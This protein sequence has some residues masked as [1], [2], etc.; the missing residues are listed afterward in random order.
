M[1]NR[2]HGLHLGLEGV[3]HAYSFKRNNLGKYHFVADAKPLHLVTN[4]PNT[5][6]NKPQGSVLLFGD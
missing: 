6:K 2:M 4:L 1:L 3:L 5:R